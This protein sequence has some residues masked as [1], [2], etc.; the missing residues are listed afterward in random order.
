MT[1]LSSLVILPVSSRLMVIV[2]IGVHPRFLVC[3]FR[4]ARAP[5]CVSRVAVRKVLNLFGDVSD[6]VVLKLKL[7]SVC[8]AA[9]NCASRDGPRHASVETAL[10]KSA[11]RALRWRHKAQ[12]RRRASR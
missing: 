4:I 5:P 12:P 10:F 2:V 11:R 3:L 8:T 1:N 9:A 7:K 6:L